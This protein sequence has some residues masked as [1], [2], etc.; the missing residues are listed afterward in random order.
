MDDFIAVAGVDELP[1]G[2]GT[3]V[4]V[5]GKG[6]ALFNVGGT[7][8]AMANACLHQGLSLGTGKLEGKIVTCRAHGWRYDVTTGCTLHVKDYGV[9]TYPVKIVDGK[10]MVAVATPPPTPTDTRMKGVQTKLDIVEVIHHVIEWAALVVELLAVAVIVAGVVFVVLTRGTVR[11][12]FHLQEHGAY[13]RYKQQLGR[14]LLL[15]LE[16]LVA[17]DVIRTVALAPTLANVAVLGLLV[18]V[19][20]MLSW[21]LTVEMEGRWPWQAKAE[22]PRQHMRPA[23]NQ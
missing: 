12:L 20:T 21:S 16:L 1:P 19:R 2:T 3:T 13:E 8:Y 23:E 18:L 5:A 22:A 17:A 4:T 14:P 15:G 11:Y 10:I 7:I 9:A 6:V